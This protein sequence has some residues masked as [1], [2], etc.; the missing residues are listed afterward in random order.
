MRNACFFSKVRFS[1]SII[2]E[3]QKKKKKKRQQNVWLLYKSSTE[4]CSACFHC[5]IEESGA[6]DLC[7]RSNKQSL[8]SNETDISS[9]VS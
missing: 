4:S 3:R 1:A 6:A 7:T 2:I 9:T 8:H 5:A